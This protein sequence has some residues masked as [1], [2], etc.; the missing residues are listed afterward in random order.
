M[1]V[2]SIVQP[3]NEA[4]DRAV[5][6]L[7]RGGLVGMPTETVYGLAADATN[8]DAVRSIFAAKG[9]PSTNPLILHLPDANA[10]RRWVDF[11]DHDWLEESWRV[12]AGFWPGPLTVVVPRSAD[13]HDVVTAGLDTVGIR[14]PQHPVARRLLDACGFPLAAPS[15][16][17]SNYVSPTLAEHVVAG[18][19]DRVQ[20]ILDGGVCQCGVESTIIRLTPDGPQLLR[21]GTIT[22]EQLTSV[23]GTSVPM[24]AVRGTETT[25]M[26]SPGLLPK[27]YSPR[28]PVRF[29]DRA[30]DV[31]T[32]RVARIAFEQI[33]DTGF[34]GLWTL[35]P[36][37]DLDE[38]ARR[39][40]GALREADQ[41]GA[42][43]IIVDRCEESGIGRAIMDR[44]R[45]ACGVGD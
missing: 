34:L 2:G 24:T 27:H 5:G 39:L 45:R 16:N 37:G 44:L 43:A 26:P 18:L 14:V 33:N 4:I 42:E 20:F 29:V 8:S 41:I 9:R 38:V 10:A 11:A 32:A 25:A 3:T 28:T 36:V 31:L 1:T 35:S 19:G 17:P 22:S 7:R 30:G 15:A 23:F 12:A 40:F 21:P 13:V 6:V